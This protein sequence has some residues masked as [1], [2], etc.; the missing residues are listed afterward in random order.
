MPSYNLTCHQAA[1]SQ[2]WLEQRAKKAAE[3]RAGSQWDLPAK[4]RSLNF[5][6]KAMGSYI[7]STLQKVHPNSV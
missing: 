7:K 3:G 4:V 2:P 6:L 1:N 5:I